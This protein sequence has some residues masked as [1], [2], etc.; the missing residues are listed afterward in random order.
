MLFR[1]TTTHCIAVT[2][3]DLSLQVSDHVHAHWVW[4]HVCY[5]GAPRGKLPNALGTTHLIDKERAVL[6][7]ADSP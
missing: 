3:Y 7:D 1:V 4:R 5:K 6:S 2:I